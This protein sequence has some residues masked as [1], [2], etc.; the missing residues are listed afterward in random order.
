[1]E[2]QFN[3]E[4]N[5]NEFIEQK[6]Q[7]PFGL[8]L[9]CVLSFIN[10]VYQVIVGTVLFLSFNFLK[11]LFSNE[12]FLEQLEESN[13]AMGDFTAAIDAL[14]APGRSYYIILALLYAAS[15]VGV[16][17]MWKLLKKGFHIYAIAQILILIAEVLMLSNV[18]G[19]SPWGSVVITVVFISMYY[20]HYKRIME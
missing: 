14:F 1:M 9:F 6:P 19:E 10:A 20:I 11:E 13:V 18:T 15:F 4:Q 8:S 12:D 7:R 16:Y 3:N 2:D 5:C 17:Y